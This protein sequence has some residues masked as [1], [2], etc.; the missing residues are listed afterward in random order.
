M[1]TTVTDCSIEIHKSNPSFLISIL[2]SCCRRPHPT[3]SDSKLTRLLQN[4]LGGNSYTTLLATVNPAA[5]NFDESVNTLQFASRCR[6]VQNLVCKQRNI[7]LFQAYIF[8]IS[9]CLLELSS[10]TSL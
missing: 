8:L 7:H 6:N 3:H 4:S 5:S 2:F 10:S 9:Y 1:Y